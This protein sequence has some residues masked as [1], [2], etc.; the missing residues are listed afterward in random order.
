MAE[1]ISFVVNGKPVSVEVDTRTLLVELL[2]RDLRLTG[3]H[4][5]CD[6]SQCGCCVLP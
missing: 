1:S 3:S 2:R 4:V 5:G 6:T